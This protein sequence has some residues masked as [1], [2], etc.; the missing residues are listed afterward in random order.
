MTTDKFIFVTSLLLIS[1]ASVNAVL[2][3]PALPAIA[4]YFSISS[5]TAQLTMTWFLI[6]YAMGQ[7]V[8]GPLANRF[9]RKPAL[10]VGVILQIFSSL[11]CVAA[12]YHHL[13]SLL[14][15][16]RILLALGSGVGLKMTFTLTNEYYEPKIASQKLA[17]LTL[18]F[19]ITP[20]LS[21][22]L[23]G[24]LVAH[25]GWISCF[26]A[27]AVYGIFVLLLS[28]NLPETLKTPDKNAFQIKHLLINYIHQFK[29]IR[30]LG[31]GLLMG[32]SS[33]SIYVFAALAP[34]IAIN[35]LHM[36]AIEYGAANILP[37]VGLAIGS[38][39]SAYLAKKHSPFWIIKTGIAVTALGI[40]ALLVTISTQL[41]PLPALF[42]PMMSI[43][44]GTA[45]IIANA[46]AMA[47]SYTQDKSHGSA[48]MNF[49][50]MALATILVLSLGM[51][52]VTALLL[53][54]IYI[55]IIMLMIGSYK[56]FTTPPEKKS[57]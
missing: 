5:S 39:T 43:Y 28:L 42:I 3:T 13:F 15:L 10:Y 40:I 32:C 26:Y 21:V 50:N 37:S 27:G 24:F 45:L 51:F 56:M 36:K 31:G 55:F 46:S 12:G 38:L 17:Y 20:G 23:G 7:L 18:A 6:A 54:A 9:G 34:F 29:N 2:F 14:I 1:F 52:N 11:L 35:L 47:M 22:A 19:A 57:L 16:G 30:L 44:F 49:T 41:P 48:V 8:Y 33:G 53:P 4:H 25:F